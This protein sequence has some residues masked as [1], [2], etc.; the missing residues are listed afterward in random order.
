MKQGIDA[1]I[2]EKLMAS[3][4]PL[5]SSEL[6]SGVGASEKTVLKY[7]NIL[8]E[9]LK[10][11]GASI[12]IKQGAGSYLAIQDINKFLNYIQKNDADIYSDPVAR[13]KYIMLRLMI[14]N[15]FI[16]VYDLS[17]ELAISPSLLRSVFKQINEILPKYNLTMEHS[18][19]HGYMIKGDEKDIRNCIMKECK[20][21]ITIDD[22]F[23]QS[24]LKGGDAQQIKE[25]LSEA[26][27]RFNIAVSNEAVN[28]LVLHILVAINRIETDNPIDLDD[29]IR[30]SNLRSTPEYFVLG[31]INKQLNEIYGI[32]LPEN[33]LLYLTMHINGKQ[34]IYGHEK[35]Q[36]KV[37][38]EALKFYNKFLRNILDLGNVDF[39]DNEE[40]RIS[41]LNHI[42][43]FLNRVNNNMQINKS[44]LVNAKNEFPYAYELALYGMQIFK[45]RNITITNPEISYF[46]LHLALAI[47]KA[48]TSA[49]S[50]NILVICN[51]A[52]SVYHIISY[53]LKKNLGEKINAIK[54]IT[55]SEV[56]DFPFDD[57]HLI[58][59]TTNKVSNISRKTISVSPT[60]NFQD[61]N[62][63]H[64]ELEKLAVNGEMIMLMNPALYFNIDAKDKDEALN[65]HIEL[66]SAQ[67]T[68]PQNFREMIDVREE[69]ESTEYDNLIALPHPIETEGIPSFI[70]IARL[71]KPITWHYKKVQ[72]VIMVCTSSM[73]ETASKFFSK[74]SKIICDEELSRNIQSKDNYNDFMELFMK[75]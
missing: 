25:L 35:I 73:N 9:E 34:R 57:Y 27:E 17:D 71:N 1:K 13:Q 68:L 64:E 72:L 47:E 61:I 45:E 11:F 56:N 14:E 53:K 38:R 4:R 33:E 26:L 22:L 42:V 29:N 74:I 12:E 60:M 10:K 20:D 40:L 65:K 62:S 24:D 55:P 3:D 67:L 8:K 21:S 15:D 32:N 43:P 59:N 2:L 7:L 28:S 49:S 6:A 30:N 18:H 36:V 44:E 41:L 50:F 58:L 23:S 66:I 48:K 31:Y 54:F 63:I 5:S 37:D 46:A 39:F 69:L 51:D 75:I 70:S 16:N 52:V 19:N